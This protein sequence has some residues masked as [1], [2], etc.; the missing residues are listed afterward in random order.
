V[1]PVLWSLG[2]AAVGLAAS[3]WAATALARRTPPATPRITWVVGLPAL[4]FAWLFPFISLLGAAGSAQ[5]PPR[6][7][8]LGA[9]AAAILGV[10][11]SD[12]LLNREEQRVPAAR[13]LACWLL[14]AAALGP[15]WLV[16]LL[17]AARL[18]R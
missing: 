17:L 14:G 4:L 6:A 10:V 1:T 12:T 3:R 9:S 15:A 7:A 13:P 5:G 11:A 8:F 2:L 18:A 16:A